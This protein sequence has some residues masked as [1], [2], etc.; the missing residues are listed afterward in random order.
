MRQVPPSWSASGMCGR[1]RCA[2]DEQLLAGQRER[3]RRAVRRRAASSTAPANAIC[4]PWFES[5][6]CGS[7]SRV[8][9]ARPG[10]V[11]RTCAVDITALPLVAKMPRVLEPYLMDTSKAAMRLLPA[12]RLSP[13]L[14]TAVREAVVDDLGIGIT[15]QDDRGRLIYVNDI[16]GRLIGAPTEELLTASV[17]DVVA[18]FELFGA[19]GSPFEMARLPGRR[20]LA[21][22]TTDDVVVRFRARGGSDDRWSLIRAVPVRDADGNV[23][24]AVNVFR[25]FTDQNR[26]DVHRRFLLRAADELHASLD[27]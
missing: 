18:R 19:D 13:Q 6:L 4:Y 27:Y 14:E 1:R 17:A 15:V 9:L 22:E 12:E 26:D 25:E 3:R 21:G 5:L 7:V 10:V 11:R 24:H 20:A 16:A 2:V 8:A 23:T